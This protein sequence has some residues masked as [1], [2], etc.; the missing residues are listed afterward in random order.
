MVVLL[1]CAIVEIL[2]VQNNQ[3]L[4]PLVLCSCCAGCTTVLSDRKE[5][6]P[7]VQTVTR[8]YY[9]AITEKLFLAP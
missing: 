7:L 6:S 9:S 4:I 3:N 8:V 2:F 1:N 5:G